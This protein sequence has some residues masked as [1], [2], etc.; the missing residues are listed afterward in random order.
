MSAQDE[1]IKGAK[2]LWEDFIKKGVAGK[3]I[4][5]FDKAI[6]AIGNNVFGG[7]EYVGN[8]LK[9]GEF[10]SS[11]GK[12][13]GRLVEDETGKMVRSA[14]KGLDYGK[15]A[16]SYMGVAAAGRVVSGGG[17]YRDKNGN[18]DIIGIPFV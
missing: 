13:F 12:T 5:G 4:N 2:T 15:I 8:V 9:S 11:F 3:D 17:L 16:G 7:A 18:T 14:E 10:G 6:N 1:V